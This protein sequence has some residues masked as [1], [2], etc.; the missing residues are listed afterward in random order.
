MVNEDSVMSVTS[1]RPGA[2]G[3]SGKKNHYMY[4][5]NIFRGDILSNNNNNNISLFVLE[6]HVHWKF[7]NSISIL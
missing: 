2:S 3:L 4:V 1:G 5:S 7:Y 6:V